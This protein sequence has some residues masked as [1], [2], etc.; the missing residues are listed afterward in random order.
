M[1]KFR[2]IAAAT[3]LVLS[4]ASCATNEQ[5]KLLVIAEEQHCPVI[6][7]G[8]SVYRSSA[9]FSKAS[10]QRPMQD[11]DS[12]TSSNINLNN[13]PEGD[14]VIV[15]NLGQK[16]SAGYGINLQ[17]ATPKISSGVLYINVDELS[18]SEGM[19]QAAVMTM[20]CLILSLKAPK[21]HDIV[22]RSKLNSWRLVIENE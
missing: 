4:H 13:L 10:R 8:L 1:Q 18:P 12:L 19:I 22:V 21:V 3:L 9:E 20:P 2:V 11:I 6:N 17:Q 5:V 15:I 7:E 16:N 14:W